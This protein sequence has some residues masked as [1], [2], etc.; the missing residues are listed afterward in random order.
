MSRTLG[1]PVRR[2]ALAVALTILGGALVAHAFHEA[3]PSAAPLKAPAVAPTAATPTAVAAR[4]PLESAAGSASKPAPAAPT[5][6]Y[7]SAGMVVGIDPETGKLGLP[8]KAQRAA[9]D[10]AASLS[11]AVDRSGTGLTVIH[12]PD[13]SL[14]VDLQGHFQDYAVVRIAPDG[15]KSESCVQESGLDA[16][17][18]GDGAPAAPAPSAAAPATDSEP[19]R[20][21]R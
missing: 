7:G 16:A 2:V 5:A 19:P 10:R 1:Y 18:H 11:P 6:P 21:E 20:A 4:A 14:M 12:K 17:L 3:R 8:T 13:G 9:L 15:T